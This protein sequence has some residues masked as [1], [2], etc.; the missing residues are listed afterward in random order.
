MSLVC[1]MAVMMD[2]L[3]NL[4]V[5]LVV[6]LANLMM[7]DSQM[8]DHLAYLTLKDPW[9]QVYSAERMVE[10]LASQMMKDSQTAV[11]WEQC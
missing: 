3:T 11:H 8:A 5:H 2:G 7:K 10:T 4:E 9:R 1:Q 6:M